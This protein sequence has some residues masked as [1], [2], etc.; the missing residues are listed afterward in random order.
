MLALRL[1]LTRPWEQGMVTRIAQ[2]SGYFDQAHFIR[3]FRAFVGSAPGE[4]MKRRLAERPEH[5]FWKGGT[6][7][8]PG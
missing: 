1:V 6:G 2:D 3:D 5:E 4:F 8:I 7:N